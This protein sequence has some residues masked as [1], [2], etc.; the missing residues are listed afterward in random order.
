MADRR[1]GAKRGPN[2]PDR[3]DRIAAAALDVAARRGVRGV[4]HR[5]AAEAAGVPLGSTTYHFASLD[6]LLAAAT[7][8][9]VEDYR[10]EL[11]AWSEA[12]ERDDVELADAIAALA[13][14]LLEPGS[15]RMKVGYD[16]YFEALHRPGLRDAA[17]EWAVATCNE[18]ERHLPT[19]AARALTVILDG[20][21][22]ERLLYGIVL[23]D[24]ELAAIV[25]AVLAAPLAWHADATAGAP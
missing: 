20:V 6:D 13:A 21:L 18:L 2:D 24:D 3:R 17:H 8:R 1:R 9:A 5:T 22:I 7:L 16:L 4:T 15:D 25:R 14:D 19:A 10:R 11:R 12:V 23:S